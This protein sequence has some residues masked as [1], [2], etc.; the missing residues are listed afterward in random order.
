MHKSRFAVLAGSI[1]VVLGIAAL[2]RPTDD[3]ILRVTNVEAIVT[4]IFS[5]GVENQWSRR[6]SLQRSAVIAV[7]QLPDGGHARILVPRTEVAVGQPV[8]LTM[9]LYENGDRK[10]VPFRQPN[11][12]DNLAGEIDSE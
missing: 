4:E 6:K 10:V 8:Q 7:V 2:T 11:A 9:T 3:D 12:T 1:A 5:P